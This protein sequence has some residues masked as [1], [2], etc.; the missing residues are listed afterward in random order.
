MYPSGV[1]IGFWEQGWYGR[2]PMK[3]FEL[4]FR[5]DGTISGHGV[6]VVGRFVFSGDWEP[7]TGRVDMTKQYLKKHQVHYTGTPDGEGSILGTWTIDYAGF[8]DTGPF[9]MSPHLAKPT[10]DDPIQEIRK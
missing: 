3:E 10:D 2:Q 1:W 5:P 6:D 9:G 7:K 8:R 4:H